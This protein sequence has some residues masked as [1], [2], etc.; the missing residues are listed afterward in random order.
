[1]KR[2]GRPAIVWLL[3]GSL[4]LAVALTTVLVVLDAALSE[5]TGLR[6]QISQLSERTREDGP[7]LLDDIAPT[8]TLDFLQHN[9]ELPRRFF[10]DQVGW[11]LV[12]SP[13]TT[14]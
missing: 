11:L 1:M 4:T 8:A 10:Q 14:G 6:R 7:L 12:S 2:P 13:A 3:V 9:A 5:R